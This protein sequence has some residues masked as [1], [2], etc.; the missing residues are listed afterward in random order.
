MA[1]LLA[2]AN[3]MRTHKEPKEQIQMRFGEA[4]VYEDLDWD[5]GCAVFCAFMVTGYK[6]VGSTVRARSKVL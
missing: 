4:N 3:Y 2:I 1:L 5:L 6:W